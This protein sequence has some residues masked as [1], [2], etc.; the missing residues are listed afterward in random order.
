MRAHE[1]RETARRRR[2]G[3]QPAGVAQYAQR[4]ARLYADTAKLTGRPVAS[5]VSCHSDPAT[6]A[7]CC[8]TAATDA[9]TRRRWH[10]GSS[11]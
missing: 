8:A 5:C 3:G 9:T 11:R 2:P 1:D 4:G 7:S 10:A 6:C